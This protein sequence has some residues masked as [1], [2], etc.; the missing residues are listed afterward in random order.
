LDTPEVSGFGTSSTRFFLF[1]RATVAKGTAIEAAT[2]KQLP[3]H[4]GKRGYPLK[5]PLIEQ[6]FGPLRRAYFPNERDL[7]I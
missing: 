4:V 7:S 2:A 1:L 6:E 3:H 5:T